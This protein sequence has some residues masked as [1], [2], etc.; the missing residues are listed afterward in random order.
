MALEVDPQLSDAHFYL[1]VTYL[2]QVQLNKAIETLKIAVENNPDSEKEHWYLGH[3]YL[4]KGDK[5]NVLR[6]MQIVADLGQERYSKKAGEL[7]KKI[8][9]IN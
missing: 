6:E 5:Q 3:A 2:F 1:G 8:Q 4:R 9:E 7:I